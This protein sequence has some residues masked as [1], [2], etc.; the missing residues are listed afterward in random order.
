VGSYSAHRATGSYSGT[1]RHAGVAF[2]S[3]KRGW[4]GHYRRMSAR[5]EQ[6]VL[7]FL[8]RTADAA[9]GT[10]RSDE[11]MRFIARL[12]ASIEQQRRAAGAVEPAEIRKVLA[13]FGDPKVLVEREL[14][15]L[16]ELRRTGPAPDG[17]VAHGGVADGAMADSGAGE[18]VAAEGV[19]AH[20]GLADRAAAH[21][22]AADGAA[23]HGG[24]ADGAVAG[25][26][27]ADGGLVPGAAAHGGAAHGGAANRVVTNGGA[28]PGAAK[29]GHVAASAAAQ[30]AFD[31]VAVVRRFAREMLAL[32]LLGLGGLLLPIPLWL[33]GAAVGLTSRA[34]R[35]ADKFIGIAGPLL[36]TVAGVGVI[37]ALNKN[38]SIPVDLHAYV[39]AAH[40]DA[41]LFVRIGAALGTA[42]LAARLPRGRANRPI[43]SADWRRDRIGRR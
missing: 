21:G 9:H 17:S 28:A 14:R 42:Y 25:S 43:R 27:A 1:A 10:L 8:S 5:S 33:I 30:I 4:F 31:P 41:S 7:D 12:R 26:G 15:R 11:R 38:P 34:W 36:F 39:A 13:A 35:G 40:A 32:L 23:A 6:I 2:G 20:G 19:A 18:G 37:G 16:Q 3:H 24:A 22:G 29:Q